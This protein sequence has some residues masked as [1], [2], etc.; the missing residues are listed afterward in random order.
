MDGMNIT[1][2]KANS[3]VFL[4]RSFLQGAAIPVVFTATNSLSKML[5]QTEWKWSKNPSSFNYCI[6]MENESL[7]YLCRKKY[8]N[9]T[10]RNSLY[11][12]RFP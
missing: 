11:I 9:D 1:V 7:F 3:P 4:E 2:L 12:M 6:D 5:L 10:L 8:P